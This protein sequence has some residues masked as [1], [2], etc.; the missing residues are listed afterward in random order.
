MAQ[1]EGN[2]EACGNYTVNAGETEE[3]W[4]PSWLLFLLPFFA[5]TKWTTFNARPHRMV[6]AFL[7]YLRLSY[8]ETLMY[9]LYTVILRVVWLIRFQNHCRNLQNQSPTCWRKPEEIHDLDLSLRFS[10]NLS[11]QF[12]D[13]LTSSRSCR[14]PMACCHCR[15]TSPKLRFPY[16]Q[17]CQVPCLAFGRVTRKK[18][19]ATPADFE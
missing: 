1:R 17:R 15:P 19:F 13:C 10:P 12:H 5:R 16:E 14:I 18:L 7:N 2:Y 4:N 9:I 11:G 6:L 3:L 8:A